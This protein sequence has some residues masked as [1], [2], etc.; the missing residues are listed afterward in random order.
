VWG[1]PAL[2]VDVLKEYHPAP[3]RSA[4]YSL[5]DHPHLGQ[6]SP[7]WHLYDALRKEILALDPGI[8]EEI[9]KLYIAYKAETNF[10]DVIPL[11][12]QLSLT[13]NMPFGDIVDPRGVATDITNMGRWGNGDVKV[14][15]DSIED[16]PYVMGLIRQSLERQLGNEEVA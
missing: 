13:L 1:A 10:V 15:L 5:S 2:P 16:I 7:S 9:L 12:R 11:A 14:Y 4:G 6:G 3:P 8:T